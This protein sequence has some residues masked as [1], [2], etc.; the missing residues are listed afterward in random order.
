[1]LMQF[2]SDTLVNLS[3]YISNDEKCQC[4]FHGPKM[5]RERKVNLLHLEVE[6]CL[7]PQ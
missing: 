6:S 2:S 4:D 7:P 1:M 3:I 5:Q